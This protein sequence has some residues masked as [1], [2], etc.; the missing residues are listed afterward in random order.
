MAD[1]RPG[2]GGPTTLYGRHR[3]I[4]SLESLLGAVRG[5]R[6]AVLVLR[7]P[8]GIGKSALLEHAVERAAD[9]QVTRTAGVQ[10]EMELP[11]AGLQ[12][13]CA[14]ML[15]RLER[16]PPPQ[17]D[18]LGTAFGLVAGHAPDRFFVAL[19]VLA[20]VS[21]AADE[22]PLL[23]VVDDAQWLDAASAQTLAFVARRLD[24]ESVAMLFAIREPREPL[25]GLPELV[26][27]G[28][29]E[30]AARDLLQSAINAPLD[31]RVQDRIILEARGN[32]L[33]LLELPRELSPAELAGGFGL[34]AAV[35]SSAV[36]EASFQR[37]IAALPE[38]ARLILLVAAADSLGDPELVWRAAHRLGVTTAAAGDAEAS[39]LLE[40]GS[41]VRFRHPLVRSAVYQA[42]SG[43]DRRRVH[44]A[45]ADET[46]RESDPDRRA[47]HRAQATAGPNDEIADELER[48]AS[49][50][51]QRGGFAAAGAFLDR[52]VGM[53]TDPAR[54]A[55]LALAAARAKY[56]AGAPDDAL[57]LLSAAQVGPLDDLGRARVD[58]LRAQLS[59]ALSRGSDAVLLLLRAAKRL[60]SLDAGL[61]RA[62]YMD[63]LTAAQFAGRLARNGGVRE[64]AEAALAMAAS[65]SE[66]EQ[67]AD[68]LLAGLAMRFT[69]GY[70]ASVPLLKRALGG[71]PG[72]KMSSE[73][74]LRWI[75]LAGHAAVDLW[76][77][78]AWETMAERH[79]QLTRDTGAVTVL[80]LALSIR[81]AAYMFAG[82]LVAAMSLIEEVEA[83]IQ[84]TGSQMA[85]YG[86]L[87]VAAWQGHED[88]VSKV[89]TA[90]LDEVV[91]RG[92]GLGVT[93]TQWAQAL[94]FNGV[95]RYQEAVAAALQASEHPEDLG[96][97]NW[98]LFELVAAAAHSGMTDVAAAA[99]DRL[100]SM[101]RASGTDWGLG[102]E[103]HARALLSE[104]EAAEQLFAEAIERLGRTRIRIGLARAHLNYGEWLRR[105]GRRLDAREELR[106]AHDLFTAMSAEGF[107]GRAE[108]ELLATGGEARKRGPETREDLTTQEIQVARLAR[109][110]LSNAEIGA[111]L[112]IS[113][114]TVEYHLHKVF[115]KLGI[116]SRNQLGRVLPPDRDGALSV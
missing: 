30:G 54:R 103:A 77:D 9:F 87:L 94:V 79:L 18:A 101:T 61:A 66:S 78:A 73:E 91:P 3:E 56:L 70:A 57:R 105:E 49:R 55:Q 16:L 74:E 10:S 31:P 64:V 33:V 98:G 106:T 104:G 4:R 29:P 114:R 34:P 40:I 89:T 39:G 71:D 53:T 47:W 1:R 21:E 25:T 116:N 85:P 112:F 36:A 83:A 15:D 67:A 58:L 99:L 12:Q 62:T 109:D 42:A 41:V 65:P 80:P 51:E 95:G 7:G 97:S 113:P 96:F 115:I 48:S 52:A 90:I 14:P 50:A 46:D 24:A 17:R 88:E 60:E 19:A 84:A 45:L 92:E 59:F 69:G 2:R 13:L 76:D 5:G 110:G 23:C 8:A 102:V 44:A 72:T 22:R 6:S 27:E 43:P 68:L 28:L 93:I 32:P 26:I 63:A 111:R 38:E 108:R 20:L 11:L 86:R 82:E 81:I 35:P 37:R 75:W 100:S 107:A